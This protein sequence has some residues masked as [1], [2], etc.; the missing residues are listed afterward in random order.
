MNG[1][2]KDDGIDALLR[3]Q[4]TYVDDGGFTAR[5][6]AALPRHHRRFRLRSALL[7][8]A[9]AV[10]AALAI[11]WLPWGNLTL[12]HTSALLA[13]DAKVLMPWMS[14]LLVAASVLWAAMAAIQWED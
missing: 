9:A 1:P 4:N 8:G 3:D 13:L 5:V 6:I 2:E 10:G 12:P 7:T 11:C 14:V